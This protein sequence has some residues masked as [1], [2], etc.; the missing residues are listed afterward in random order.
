MWR[1][2]QSANDPGRFA[3]ETPIALHLAL[4][5][6]CFRADFAAK[7]QPILI[8]AAFECETG[9]QSLLK[10]PRWLTFPGFLPPVRPVFALKCLPFVL[11]D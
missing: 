2:E 5:W 7:A 10:A 1:P 3:T 8:F 4:P 9:I 11:I 6:T